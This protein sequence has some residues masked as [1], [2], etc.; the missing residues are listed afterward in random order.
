MANIDQVISHI[1]FGLD[2]LSA[3]NA[4]HD[5]EHLCRHLTR[6]RICSNVLPSTG[7]V[8]A[9]GDQGRD[10][11]TFRT[12]LQ[13]SPIA[14]S[15]F[16][17]LVSDKPIAFACSLNKKITAKIKSD[18]LTIVSSGSKVEAIHYFCAVDLSTA[19][20]H[21]LKAWALKEHSIE[22][23]IHDG[24]SISEMLSDRDVF[25]IAERYL[26]ISGEIYPRSPVNDSEGWY[27][28]FLKKCKE[29]SPPQSHANFFD[30][31]LA[32]RNALLTPEIKQDLPFW[33]ELLKPYINSDMPEILRRRSVYEVAVLSIRGLGTLEGQEDDLRKYFTIIP[34]MEEPA[35]I[36][37]ASVLLNYCVYACSEHRCDLNLNELR[38]R[39][40]ELTSLVDQLLSQKPSANKEAHLLEERGYLCLSVLSTGPRQHQIDEG[41]RW[42][43]KLMTKVESAPLFPLEEF[44]DL[45]TKFIH[46]FDGLPAYHRLTQKVDVLLSKRFGAF[47]AAEK[48]RDRALALHGAGKM[49]GAINQLHQSKINW[50]AA[51]AM[52]YS[53][54]SMLLIAQCYQ[55]LGLFFAAKYYALGVASI[56]L[57]SQ[58]TDLKP[59]I[60]RALEAAAGYDYQQGAWCSFLELTGM[61]LLNHQFFAEEADDISSHWYLQRSIYCV[62]NMKVLTERIAPQLISLIDNDVAMWQMTDFIEDLI[63][64]G[65]ESWQNVKDSELFTK[66]EQ[67]LNGP[68]FSDLGTRRKALWT[69]LGIAWRVHWRNDYQTTPIAEGFIAFLQILLA[70]LA[71]IDLCLLKTEVSIDVSV[72]DDAQVELKV[73]PSKTGRA[74]K[75]T[76]PDHATDDRQRPEGAQRDFVAASLSILADL[77][78]ASDDEYQKKTENRFRK[79]LVSKL[80]VGQPYETIYRGFIPKNIFKS[81]VRLS[82]KRPDTS[83]TFSVKEYDE[84][85][86]FDGPGPG[87]SKKEA[88]RWV[89]N[90]YK[91]L[92]PPIIHTL[93]RLKGDRTFIRAVKH[94]RNDGWL[95]WHILSAVNSITLNFGTSLHPEARDN[96]ALLNQLYNEM[97]RRSETPSDPLVPLTY[98]TEQTMR[99]QLR[100]NMLST[101]KQRGFVCRQQYPDLKAIEDFLRYR[102][103]YWSDDIEHEPLPF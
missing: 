31:K 17:G 41:F 19:S 64:S 51:E 18:V 57:H 27:K 83:V 58:D 37:D 79:G 44:A 3:R 56:A 61:A 74:W 82:S 12:Y 2:Q 10:F 62:V 23:E 86:W 49:L 35:D 50:F 52:E 48:C 5:F 98:F 54:L 88:K 28:E 91:Y 90:R 22:L 68:P 11:E 67:G 63:P 6:Q 76:F 70:D 94:L 38:E 26:S 85:R 21:K 43:M 20:R 32:A 1:R 89:R 81:E 92:R 13:A 40:R 75:L 15:T 102:Y 33:I 100:L 77:S 46:F 36:K 97:M 69:E 78:L 7:P 59:F 95:D 47:T 96:P 29:S 99:Y 60:P 24:Q 25:W 30:I 42:W 14:S 93:E 55:H 39:W 73:S 4:H 80:L 45:L 87:Y 84:L 16:I 66:L 34:Q 8:S 53:L 103:N 72:T 9:G 65:R 71:N 101:I